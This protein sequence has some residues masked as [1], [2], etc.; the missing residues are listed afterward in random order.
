MA[1]TQ[2]G[3][4]SSRQPVPVAEGVQEQLD[5]KAKREKKKRSIDDIERELDQTTQRLA[6]NV[7]EL[8]NRVRP[9]RLAQAGVESAKRKVLTPSGLPRPEVI[10]AAVGAV[11]V[12]VVLWRMRRRS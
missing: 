2:Q 6:A 8:V 7:D 3:L 9:S 4:P 12:G 10:G 5:E 11:V 1:Q